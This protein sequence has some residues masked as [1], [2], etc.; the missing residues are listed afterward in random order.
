V[1]GTQKAKYPNTKTPERE[2][3]FWYR[4]RSRSYRNVQMRRL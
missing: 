4:P 3:I 2:K 1:F